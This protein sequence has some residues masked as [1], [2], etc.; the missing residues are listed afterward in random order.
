M[1]LNIV[2]IHQIDAQIRVTSRYEPLD[3]SVAIVDVEWIGGKCAGI[4]NMSW[5]LTGCKEP[6]K[7]GLEFNFEVCEKILPMRVIGIE[8]S[9]VVVE[10]V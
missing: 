2:H 8:D 3:Q 10:R 5:Y 6:I 7:I 9:F 4:N 1:N